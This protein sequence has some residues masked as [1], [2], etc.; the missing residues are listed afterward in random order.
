MIDRQGEGG[1]GSRGKED[2]LRRVQR[3]YCV[4]ETKA[5]IGMTVGGV[6]NGLTE[7]YL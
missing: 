4:T 5:D 2:V 7:D 3:R 1:K 6:A